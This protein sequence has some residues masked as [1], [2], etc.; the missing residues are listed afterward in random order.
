MAF[1][2]HITCSKD[3]DK[4]SIDFSDGTSVITESKKKEE[5][6]KQNKSFIDT[7]VEY[8]DISQDIIEKPNIIREEKPIKV[9]E[10]LQNF[11]F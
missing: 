2:L 8:S 1:E 5:P 3:I 10:E 7:D 6:V 11:N 9:A 4:L